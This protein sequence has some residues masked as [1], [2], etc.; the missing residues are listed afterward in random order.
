MSA[1]LSHLSLPWAVAYLGAGW[2][3][4]GACSGGAQDQSLADAA[5]RDAGSAREGERIPCRDGVPDLV[6]SFTLN[7]EFDYVAD[8]LGSEVL[9]SVGKLCAN[10]D[11]QAHC[12]GA[13]QRGS[14]GS[15]RHLLTTRG[16]SVQQWDTGSAHGILMPLDSVAEVA[17]LAGSLDYFVGCDVEVVR[18]ADLYVLRGA[19]ARYGC[20]NAQAYVT[21]VVNSVGGVFEVENMPLNTFVCESVP[22]PSPSGMLPLPE[23]TPPPPT[24]F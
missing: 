13:A 19:E 16:N 23:P 6:P 11:D 2:L 1:S 15:F 12:L 7:Q 5:I 17:W 18:D 4:L 20:A 21:L 8:R 9:S 10:A 24:P 22:V 14:V 3:L